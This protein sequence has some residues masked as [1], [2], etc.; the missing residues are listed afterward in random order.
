MMNEQNL[1]T[2]FYIKVGRMEGFRSKSYRC[3]HGKLTIGFGH[4]RNVHFGDI[5]TL[6]TARTYLKQDVQLCLEQIDN[7]FNGYSITLPFHQRLALADFVFNLGYKNFKT[8]TL[9]SLLITYYKSK[10]I[11]NP[12]LTSRLE[13]SIKREF[14]KWI[15]YTTPNGEKKQSSGLLERRRFERRLFFEGVIY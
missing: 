14:V 15:Y 1:L 12:T 8:S 13:E 9:S 7:H 11:K 6:E 5:I 2:E 10:T 3:P 4:T